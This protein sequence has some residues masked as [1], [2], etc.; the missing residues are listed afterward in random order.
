VE[1]KAT[2]PLSILEMSVVGN[3]RVGI[4]IVLLHDAEGA[5]VTV[6]T[7]NGQLIRGMLFEAEDM[8][9]LY[10]KNAIVTSPQGVKRKVNQIYIRGPEIVFIL[11]PDMLKHAPMFQR[12]KHWRKHGGAPPEGV[13]A[14]VGQAAA[15]LRKA[16]ERRRGGFGGRG[17]GF[18]GRGG[19]GGRGDG[20]FGGRGGF[21]PGGRGGSSFGGRVGAGFGGGRGPP[22]AGPPGGYY[23]A[24]GQY[25]PR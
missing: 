15:I 11:L 2:L 19:R 6:E 7:K 17:G 14:A 12:I 5:V 18:G 16:N 10:L 24:P 1:R 23:G 3:N 9:N 20:G 21:P 4:P 8:M 25:G 22:P 13:G